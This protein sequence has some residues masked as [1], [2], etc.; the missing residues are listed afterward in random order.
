LQEKEKFNFNH[1]GL[2]NTGWS[3]VYTYFPHYDKKQCNN[4]LGALKHSCLKWKDE[5]TTTGLGRDPRT[6]DIDAD[7]EYWDTQD[8]AQPDGVVSALLAPCFAL[9]VH[10]VRNTLL[11]LFAIYLSQGT[12]ATCVTD[13]FVCLS[14]KQVLS[15]GRR[16]RPPHHLD[17]LE[18]LFGDHNRNTGCFMSAGGIRESTPPPVVPPAD[19]SGPSSYHLGSK[20]GNWDQVMTSPEKKKS[21]GVGE[22][23]ARLSESIAARM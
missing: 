8:A 10:H 1:Q 20:R 13:F 18:A 9:P 16:G 2:T 12:C 21:F 23:F 14:R 19:F 15:G 22:Y 6:S 17:L 11:P 5:L 3:N 4:K 7:P